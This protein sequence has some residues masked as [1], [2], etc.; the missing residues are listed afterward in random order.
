[1]FSRQ[2]PADP[3]DGAYLDSRLPDRFS[4]FHL[5]GS[6]IEVNQKHVDKGEALAQLCQRLH[7][8]AEQVIVFGDSANDHPLFERFPNSV[9]MGN[10]DRITRQR[11]AHV[12]ATNNEEGVRQYLQSIGL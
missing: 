10:A 5:S 1:M 11:A 3:P 4:I 7:I 2:S 9:A 12:T 6:C 8:P